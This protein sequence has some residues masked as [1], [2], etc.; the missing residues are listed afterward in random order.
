[1]N[2]TNLPGY[3]DEKDAFGETTVTIEAAR[4]REA[5]A[6]ARDELGFRMLV[7]SDRTIGG[8]QVTSRVTSG[9]VRRVCNANLPRS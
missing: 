5:C 1:M 3:V 9:Y 6:H 7:V 4:I 2:Y 8:T